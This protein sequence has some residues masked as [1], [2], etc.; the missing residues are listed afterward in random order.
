MF[1]RE[2]DFWTVSYDGSMARFK[3]SRGLQYL[4]VL[5]RHPLQEFLAFGCQGLLRD[6]GSGRE[7]TLHQVGIRHSREH[8]RQLGRLADPGRQLASARG[9]LG[10]RGPELAP[11]T[12]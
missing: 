12:P 8:S 3:G 10:V 5:L 7:V 11:L 9:G 2:A 4:A 1:R 6:L